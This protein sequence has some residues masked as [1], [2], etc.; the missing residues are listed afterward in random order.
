MAI[1]CPFQFR[2]NLVKCEIKLCF[3]VFVSVRAGS[4]DIY[5][6]QGVAEML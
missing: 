5:K 3:I 4:A 6:K 1:S 2:K